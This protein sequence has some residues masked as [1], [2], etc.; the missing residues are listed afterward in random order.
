MGRRNQNRPP[1]KPRI[2]VPDFPTV[3]N[4]DPS[5]PDEFAVWALVGLPN[6]NGAPLPL[7]VKILRLVSRRLWDLGFRYH[8]ELRTLKYRKP[9]AG[10][11]NWLSSPGTWVPI[12]DPDP[13]EVSPEDVA[14]K[15][16]PE[17]K[18]ALRKRF[19]LDESPP[20]PV[21]PDDGGKVPYLRR[22]GSTVM[23]TAAQAARYAAAKKARREA[24][25]Q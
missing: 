15:L 21:V 22:D 7:P 11:A 5:N 14:K 6:Q 8:P 16:S 9:R 25:G 12:D 10:E 24:N 20:T 3:D 1:R 13:D 4:C 19:G 23:V 17:Q 18:A 2:T